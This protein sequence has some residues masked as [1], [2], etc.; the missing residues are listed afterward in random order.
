MTP[1]A[2]I[3]PPPVSRPLIKMQVTVRTEWGGCH[4]Y[5]AVFR[6]TWDAYDDAMVRFSNAARIEVKALPEKAPTHAPR[7]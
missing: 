6:S 7:R 2:W 1:A 4:Q 3:D 5:E